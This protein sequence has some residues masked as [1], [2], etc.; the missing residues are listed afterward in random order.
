MLGIT[1]SW[2]AYQ[3]DY[4]TAIAAQDEA[5]DAK[6]RPPSVAGLKPGDTLP[7]GRKVGNWG[8]LMGSR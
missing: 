2:E 1:N 3:L 8:M 5:R 7:D 6:D 4:V